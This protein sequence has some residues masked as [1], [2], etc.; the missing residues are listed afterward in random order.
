MPRLFI[1]SLLLVPVLASAEPATVKRFEAPA[2]ERPDASSPT[3][4]TF[5]ERTELSVSEEAE[6]GFRK[7]RLPS[8]AVAWIE[9]AALTFETPTVTAASRTEQPAADAAERSYPDHAPLRTKDEALD[10]SAK[11]ATLYI[12]DLAHLAEV[13]AVDEQVA[14]M[15]GDLARR[16][17]IGTATLWGSAGVGLAVAAVG[18]LMIPQADCQFVGSSQ[19]CGYGTANYAVAGTGVGIMTLGALAG[20][21][22][23]PKNGDLLD[24]LNAWNQ[25]HPDEP[26]SITPAAP[27]SGFGH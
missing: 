19:S 7:V 17:T 9:E 3:V 8:G 26:F 2:R 1:L 18:L 22:I 12:K 27:G 23:L 24:V 20:Y 15:A 4:H 11:K 13:V 21:L 16:Q 25:R 14:P 6:N 10:A 5:V